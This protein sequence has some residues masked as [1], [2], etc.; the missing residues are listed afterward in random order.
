MN[1][2]RIGL[3]RTLERPVLVVMPDF[4]GV[5]SEKILVPDINSSFIKERVLPWALPSLI[6]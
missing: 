2:E 6:K 1:F 3:L 5:R 4:R